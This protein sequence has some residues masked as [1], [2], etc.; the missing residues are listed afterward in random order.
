MPGNPGK[1]PMYI[2]QFEGTAAVTAVDVFGAGAAPAPFTSVVPAT[3]RQAVL[4]AIAADRRQRFMAA[5]E[6]SAR[7]AP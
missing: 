6:A 3:M 5:P 1:R 2:Q 7:L 4:A